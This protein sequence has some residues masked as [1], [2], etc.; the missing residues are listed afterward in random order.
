MRAACGPPA[1]LL[2]RPAALRQA[3]A[4][5][6]GRGRKPLLATGQA[7]QLAARPKTALGAQS[8]R[9][10]FR[11]KVPTL[12]ER[13]AWTSALG[14]IVP[15]GPSGAGKSGVRHVPDPG[16]AHHLLHKMRKN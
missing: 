3:A 5:S 4:S 14:R 9:P 16:H 1:P 13:A 11:R 6:E 10:V 12:R 7:A 2:P 8:H 15:A